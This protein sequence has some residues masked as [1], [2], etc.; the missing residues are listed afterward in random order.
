MD[1]RENQGAAFKAEIASIIEFLGTGL[2][3]VSAKTETML[4][5][6]KKGSSGFEVSTKALAYLARKG[7]VKRDSNV[8]QITV[9]A[10]NLHA[11]AKQTVEAHELVENGQSRTVSKVTAESPI[12]YLASRKDK[13][14]VSLLG[15]TEWSAGD[16][17]RT[18]FTRA[19]MLPSIGMRWGEPIRVSGG[20]GGGATQTD[21][22]LAARVRVTKAL[23]AVGPEFSGLL[24]D[25]CCFLKGLEQVE[26]ERG[27]P[28]RS[29][30]VMLR[31]GLSILARHYLPA[32]KG[33]AII[34][35]WGTEDYRP[36]I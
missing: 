19:N 8:L 27:W 18:D 34:R 21:A 23:E 28:Q 4:E 17:L 2:A 24:I 22:A 10:P 30:K 32:A 6:K 29:A 31:A 5:L 20:A 36:S 35:S 15:K 25:V 12:D 1:D 11:S 13:N 33:A 26:M 3:T 14:G 7:W 16:R 9:N